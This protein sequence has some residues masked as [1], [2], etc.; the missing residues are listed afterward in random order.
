M[1]RKGL[2]ILHNQIPHNTAMNVNFLFADIV[3]GACHNLLL[4]S[5]MFVC[6]KVQNG[7]ECKGKILLFA[8]EI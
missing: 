5:E 7:D 2:H 8:V 3:Q 6:E 1:W 4:L